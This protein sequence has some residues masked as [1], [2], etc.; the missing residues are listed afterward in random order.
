MPNHPEYPEH[1]IITF[2]KW[3]ATR[4]EILGVEIFTDIEKIAQSILTIGQP[5][6]TSSPRL[7]PLMSQHIITNFNRLLAEKTEKFQ[8]ITNQPEENPELFDWPF[9]TATFLDRIHFKRRKL[10]EQLA[11]PPET[12][13]DPNKVY[14]K[15]G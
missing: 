3:N 13:L 15:P 11:K 5:I 9:K 14:G 7:S 1:I 4:Q 10:I 12:E 6:E 8:K 2:S